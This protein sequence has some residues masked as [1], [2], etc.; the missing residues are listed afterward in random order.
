VV[1]DAISRGERP[2]LALPLFLSVLA[3]SILFSLSNRVTSRAC[4]HVETKSECVAG[5]TSQR[6]HRYIREK[7]W[8]TRLMR[9][10]PL[11]PV[12]KTVD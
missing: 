3:I 7:Q 6:Q 5:F 10:K 4:E 8:P 1:V 11:S 2:W 9:I 12:I